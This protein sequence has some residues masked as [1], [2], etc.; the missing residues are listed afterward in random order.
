MPVYITGAVKF[1]GIYETEVPVYLYKL[2]DMAGGLTDDADKLSI[3]LAFR[4]TE[5]MMIVIPE[6]NGSGLLSTGGYTDMID[7]SSLNAFALSSAENSGFPVNINTA[8]LSELCLLPGVGNSTAEAIIKYRET[9]GPFGQI[10][11][12]M[13][14]PGIKQSRFES[15]K[16]KIS[17][18][19]NN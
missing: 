11:D 6:T 5:N 9:N 17:V 12:I 18:S 8:G 7:A 1:P 10:E 13:K 2:V 14:V 4:I 16:D 15:L 3:N 19:L